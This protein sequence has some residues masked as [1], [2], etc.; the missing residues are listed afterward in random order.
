MSK[1]KQKALPKFRFFIKIK[2]NELTTQQCIEYI[3]KQFLDV[4]KLRSKNRVVR[5]F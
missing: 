3:P 4:L 5:H 1:N 2:S